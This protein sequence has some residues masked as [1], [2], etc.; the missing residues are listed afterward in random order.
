M[1]EMILRGAAQQASNNGAGHPG[2]LGGLPIPQIPP[3]MKKP[4]KSADPQKQGAINSPA[5][6]PLGV[7]PQGFPT[8]MA[9]GLPPGLPITLPPQPAAKK[10]KKANNN[11]NTTQPP[12]TSA[13]NPTPINNNYDSGDDGVLKI[14]EDGASNAG[15]DIGQTDNNTDKENIRNSASA[16]APGS[17][18]PGSGSGSPTKNSHAGAPSGGQIDNDDDIVDLENSANGVSTEEEDEEEPMA[19]PDSIPGPTGKPQLYSAIACRTH[20]LAFFWPFLERLGR[21]FLCAF[22]RTVFR[23]G[24]FTKNF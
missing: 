5:A 8:S 12:P 20:I 1:Q 15:A 10:A 4:R 24:Y 21:S 7:F 14:D 22:F 6:L 9:M 18:V 16:G 3:P 2:A 19:G 13:A 11:G 17:S 23:V